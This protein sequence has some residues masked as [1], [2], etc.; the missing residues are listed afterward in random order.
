M[1]KEKN[2]NKKSY[3]ESLGQF[4]VNNFRV[5]DSEN[6]FDFK[7]LT[8]LVGP[9]S[10]GKSSLMK[11]LSALSFSAN[12]SKDTNFVPLK[13][14]PDFASVNLN[15][16]IPK[17]TE[18]FIFIH[19][20]TDLFADLN[21]DYKLSYIKSTKSINSLQL[22]SFEIR[23]NQK[24]ILS[25]SPIERSND[26]KI[27]FYFADY[28]KLGIDYLKLGSKKSSLLHILLHERQKAAFECET[29][30]KLKDGE[31]ELDQFEI[32]RDIESK[33]FKIK[34]FKHNMSENQN[35]AHKS[36][37]T[38]IDTFDDAINGI[39]GFI[40]Y[41]FFIIKIKFAQKI[42]DFKI[43]DNLCYT[44]LGNILTNEFPESISR[45]LNYILKKNISFSRAPVF[46][47]ERESIFNLFQNHNTAFGLL[48]KSYIE[49]HKY[50]LDN[51]NREITSNNYIDYWLKKFDIGKS[52]IIK[53][54]E[55]SA[56][57][58]TI[59]IIRNSG[60]KINICDLGYGAGQVL[61]YIM[62]PFFAN[63]YFSHFISS[64]EFQKTKSVKAEAKKIGED[65]VRNIEFNPFRD[66][67]GKIQTHFVYLEEPETNL[68][69][70][71][72]STLAE[73]FAYQIK[74][75]IRF[76]IETHSEYFIRKIQNLVASNH[77]D[78]EDFV[79][80]YFNSEK[81]RKLNNLKATDEIK[82]NKNG[83]LSK[84]FGP[85][86]F[87]EAGRLSLEL[88]TLN[89]ISKN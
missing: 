10:S 88:L 74:I 52:L 54:I 68:H 58:Y 55:P 35:Y 80:Y 63:V 45:D 24:L 15:S 75:G 26:F 11:L 36:L 78:N 79:M 8:F 43:L 20:G 47:D 82:I 5:F 59:E 84:S 51:I 2:K 39:K 32:L 44:E 25:L 85:G 23:R 67:E 40:K 3:P 18:P 27:L 34:E 30:I 21:L 57:F 83:T 37:V 65:L 1:K 14:T 73:L 41:L 12:E 13:I 64:F 16:A 86:F 29:V 49:Q 9:N 81:E 4:S 17:E 66:F 60:D 87:D 33:V 76:A 38:S 62:L 28:Y 89:S 7:P 61:A 71:W 42:E 53:S 56:Q 69:P 77:C 19:Q 70:N 6:S 48:I 31:L 46:K 72:Q 50:L 22:S